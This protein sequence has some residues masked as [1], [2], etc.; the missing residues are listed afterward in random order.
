MKSKQDEGVL[1]CCAA[2]TVMVLC[3]VG[4]N[5]SRGCIELGDGCCGTLHCGVCDDNDD[6][7][8]VAVLWLH[9]VLLCQ[10]G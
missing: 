8:A 1:L 6:K 7:V 5:L 4:N 3:G 9:V 2:V 10:L